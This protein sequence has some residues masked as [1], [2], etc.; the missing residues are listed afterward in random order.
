MK[1][2]LLTGA[3]GCMGGAALRRFME[4]ENNGLFHLRLLVRDSQKNRALMAPYEGRC[5]IVWGDLTDDAL[6]KECLKG[7]DVVLDPAVFISPKCDDEPEEAFKVN[8]GATL[9]MIKSLHELG[10]ADTTRFLYVGSCAMTG[11]RMPPIHWGR[12]GDPLKPAAYDYYAVTKV[13]SEYAVLESGLKYFASV[14]LGA[15]LPT[16][17]EDDGDPIG[18]QQPL[19]NCLEWTDQ[20][21]AGNLLR[22]IALYAPDEFWGKCYNLSSGADWRLTNVQLMMDIGVDI[23][24]WYEPN[25]V[26]LH[27]FHGQWYLDADELEAIVPFRTRSYQTM[28]GEWKEA[29]M[30]AVMEAMKNIPNFRMPTP[31]ETRQ[32][33]YAAVTKPRGTM[34]AVEDNNETAIKVWYGSREKYEAIPRDWD[35][36]VLTRPLEIKPRKPLSRG[37]DESK[38]PSELD[39]EDMREAARFRGG[40]C[41]SETMVK[42]DLYTPLKWRSADGYEFEARPYTVLFAGHWSPD[43]LRREWRYGHIAKQNT[44]FNQV[45][46]PLHEGEDDD[47]TVPMACDGTAEEEKYGFKF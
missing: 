40:E 41:L 18:A 5:E 28:L 4:M 6:V 31:E 17:S 25:W 24:D 15:M 9:S 46:A 1:T 35:K 3:T 47:Y 44:F 45:W 32:A 7:V 33:K 34:R 43:D 16:K 26:A 22:N 37:F 20:E 30:Q 42:G 13:K 29:N 27:N 21:D 2:I 39:I 23:R 12:I 11:E 38:S 10:Q 8:Y 14:R 19:N 36:F